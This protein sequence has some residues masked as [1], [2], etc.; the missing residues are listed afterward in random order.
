MCLDKL[1]EPNIDDWKKYIGLELTAYNMFFK[2]PCFEGEHEYRFVFMLG[3]DGGR[4][5][6]EQLWKQHF[7]V[8]DEVL[9]PF[10]KVPLKSIDSIERVL[11]GA[12]NKSDIALKGVQ[13]F[14]RNLKHD[15]IVEKSQMPLRY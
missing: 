6:P 5:K 10:I 2:L 11:V 13:Y 12:K 7:R 15:T 14:F 4:Y 9:I 8:K 3:H 1:T